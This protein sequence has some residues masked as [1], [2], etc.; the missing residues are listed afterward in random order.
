MGDRSRIARNGEYT[1]GQRFRPDKL[2]AV[3]DASRAQV[4]PEE[5]SRHRTVPG[6]QPVQ[7]FP[8]DR[9]ELLSPIG[10]E[11]GYLL[12]MVQEPVESP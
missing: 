3:G 8:R 9:L 11:V 12:S 2:E 1:L 10:V 7:V 4:D 5:H 6:R